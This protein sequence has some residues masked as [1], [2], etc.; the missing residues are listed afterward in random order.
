MSLRFRYR[1]EVLTSRDITFIN[2][3]IDEN[4][5]QLHEAPVTT[6]VRRLDETKANRQPNLRWRQN[7]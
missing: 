5:N 3:L 4:P 6:P 7:S 1:G 2:Q